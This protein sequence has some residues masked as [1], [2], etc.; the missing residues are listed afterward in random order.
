MI[1]I[2]NFEKY[3]K[4]HP[5]TPDKKRILQ[6][7]RE[8]AERGIVMG[9]RAEKILGS[10]A[11]QFFQEVENDQEHIKIGLEDIAKAKKALKL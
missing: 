1:S 8:F 11:K 4:D 10:L 5:D 2:R 7:A 9:G 6:E 3:F